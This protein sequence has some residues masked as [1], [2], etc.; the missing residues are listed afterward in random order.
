M[1]GHFEA[2]SR[3]SIPTNVERFAMFVREPVELENLIFELRGIAAKLGEEKENS[4]ALLVLLEAV[5]L[6]NNFKDLRTAR[7]FVS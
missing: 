1:G 3:N 4:N 2:K 7:K 6:P 5:M